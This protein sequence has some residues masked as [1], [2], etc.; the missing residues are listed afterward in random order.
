MFLY[1]IVLMILLTPGVWAQ[2]TFATIAGT[3]TDASGAVVPNISVTVTNQ[4]MGIQKVVTSDDRGNYE[5]THLN[6]GAY[7]VTAQP[8]GFRKF[9]HRDIM[10]EALRTVRIDLRLE[11]AGTGT[12]ITV[13]GG[14]PVV[15]TDASN[16]SD[17][18][19]S[20]QIRDL[21]L[22]ILS[23]M[24]ATG[25]SG[26]LNY[27]WLAPTGYAG[28]GFSMG[29]SH[30]TQAY[31]NV[32]GISSNSPAFGSQ[33][34]PAQ[35]AL[36]SIQ[37]IRIDM[38]N[39]KAEF[40]EVAN[41]TT[42][43]KSG[44]NQFHGGLSWMNSTSALTARSY[45]SPTKGQNILNDLGATLL[46]PIRRN[47]TF[48]L[49]TYGAQ[50]QRTPAIVTPSLPTVNM[51]QGNFSELL[52]LS[53]A[54]IIKNPYTGQPFPGNIIPLSMLDAS[55]LKWQNRFFPLPNFG[56]P[57]LFV[58][59]FR[60]AY[61]QQF[62]HDQFDVRVDQ[63]FSSKNT[64]YARVSYKRSEPVALDSGLPPDL[65]GYR[66]QIRNMRQAAVSDTWTITP[67]MVNEFKL[68]F[69]RQFNPREGILVGQELIDFLGI[70]GLPRQ[71]A[72]V[73]NIPNVRING[74]QQVT[75][76]AKAAPAENTFQVI[77]QLTYLKGRHSIKGGG[78]F[79]PQQSNNLVA[80]QFGTY[81]FANR[82]SGFSYADFLLGLPQSSQRTTSRPSVAIQFWFLNGF[83][84][85]D[86]KVSQ[87]LTLNYGVRYEYDSPAQ[88]RFNMLANFDPVTGSIVV[89]TE[90]VLSAVNPLFPKNIPILTAAQAGYP[91]RTLRE[92]DMNNL[93]P[94]F[95]FAYRPFAAMRTVLRGGYGIFNDDLTAN[96][97]DALGGGP[98]GITENFTNDIV[99]GAPLLTFTRPFLG[100]GSLGAI[101]VTGLARRIRNPYVQ[102]W[103]FTLEQDLGFSTG[104]RISYIGTK[105]TNLLYG[106]NYNQPQPSSIPFSVSRRPYP[107]FQNIVLNEN[108]GNHSYNALST[109]VERRWLQGL[110]FQAS[111]TW[112][113]NLTDVEETGATE[114]GSTIENAYDRSRQ[115]GDTIYNPRHRVITNV[116]WELPFGTGRPLAARPGLLNGLIGRWDLSVSFIAQT[117]QFLTPTFSGFDPSNTQTLGGVPDRIRDGNLPSDQRSIDHWFDTT[118][119]VVPPSGRFGNAG[120]GILEGPGHQTLNVGLFK[121]IPITEKIRL[122]VQATFTNALNHPNFGNPALNISATGSAGTIRSQQSQDSAGPR[123]GLLGLRLEF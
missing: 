88:D 72:D 34:Y 92:N 119:F 89:P 99:A 74:F 39:N 116:L 73:R 91:T 25:D 63:Y 114:G 109:Q 57:D 69:V 110:S 83:L 21:P 113:K 77:N 94:R 96:V 68:G 55:A 45:F 95:G 54:T 75:Q 42:I 40:G 10:L 90:Q 3:V 38:V 71:P 112:A 47:R 107:L 19:S 120:W 28:K 102:Q 79:R 30:G 24:S 115:R 121:R 82:F 56:P 46:G 60:A 53:P 65:T 6:P 101:N 27:V 29:G 15:E 81:T 7:S 86:F 61:P 18:K 35:P 8:T 78:E 4:E 64:L 58:A 11:L 48:F 104:L 85:D 52:A 26:V 123:S 31:F 5:A 37:E 1:A 20:R 80:P 14:T 111:W 103:N 12:E 67:R 33:N 76:V 9:E 2:A 108:G 87:K 23:T 50:R 66:V 117:G 100:R 84:Q 17:V 16:L 122:R 43:T 97:A 49:G 32:D 44:G 41:V 51:R 36:D 70:E 22:N 118:A 62:R 13:T 98:F 93:Q 106:R 105:S 59:N